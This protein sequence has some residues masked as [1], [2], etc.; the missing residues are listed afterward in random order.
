[1]QLRPSRRAFTLIELLVVIAIIAL[2]IGLL[3]PALGKAREVAR[4]TICLTKLRAVGQGQTQ[5]MLDNRDWIATHYTSGA[6]A[7]IAGG[8]PLLG[9]Q[10]PT[11]PIS[12]YD[13]L[14]PIL[15]DS[16][17]FSPRRSQRAQQIFN[18]FSCPT[19]KEFSVVWPGS[20]S[21]SDTGEFVSISE[22]T[23]GYK[24]TSYLQSFGW[25]VASGRAPDAVRLH[26]GATRARTQFPN[27]VTVLGDFQPRLD[28]MGVQ[29]SNK[30]LATDGTRRLSQLA[31]GPGINFDA[32]SDPTTFGAFTDSPGFR[33]SPSFGP[34]YAEVPGGQNIKL[35]FRHNDGVNSAFLDGSAR[36]VKR[37][38]FN[39]RI[40][41]FY[42]SKSIYTGIDGMSRI[43]SANSVLP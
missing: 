40:D 23:R 13:W 9:D 28:K 8:A 35:T 22:T 2:L 43:Y 37:T 41:Y 17:N 6:D 21:E 7:D 18:D 4:A 30:S 34:D 42:P 5:Y 3:L 25:A 33:A 14:S 27:P 36:Y 15:G 10:K 32:T 12:T 16:L 1:M 11:T 39:D 31:T 24:S 38:E 29:P 26:K 19:V 20:R